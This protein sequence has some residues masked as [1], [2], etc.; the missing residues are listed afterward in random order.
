[1]LGIGMLLQ[2][3]SLKNQELKIE[4]DFHSQRLFRTPSKTTSLSAFDIEVSKDSNMKLKLR[5][6]TPPNR[7]Q[8]ERMCF[9]ITIASLH[10]RSSIEYFSSSG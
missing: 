7:M 1:M 8:L 10:T 3:N 9:A 2:N 6:L 4:Q 5:T